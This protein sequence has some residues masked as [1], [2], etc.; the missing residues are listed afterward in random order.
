M[1]SKGGS[2][3]DMALSIGTYTTHASTFDDDI[4]DNF[5]ES[6][7]KV[8]TDEAKA[9]PPLK[10]NGN[11]DTFDVVNLRGGDDDDDSSIVSADFEDNDFDALVGEF[12]WYLRDKEKSKM[13][14]SKRLS[15]STPEQTPR[16][17]GGGSGRVLT[18]RNTTR[19]GE[20]NGVDASKQGDRKGSSSSFK[21]DD[22]RAVDNQKENVT[23]RDSLIQFEGD[24]TAR[25]ANIE[26]ASTDAAPVDEAILTQT[27][28]VLDDEKGDG[29]VSADSSDIGGEGHESLGA[30]SVSSNLGSPNENDDPKDAEVSIRVDSPSPGAVVYHDESRED[31]NTTS[32]KHMTPSRD[33]SWNEVWRKK[34]LMGRMPT[35][36]K[37]MSS[38]ID[39]LAREAETSQNKEL[40]LSELDSLKG[41]HAIT[42]PPP[43][44]ASACPPPS[45]L[46]KQAKQTHDVLGNFSDTGSAQNSTEFDP[47]VELSKILDEPPILEDVS[48]QNDPQSRIPD[49][50]SM[51][52]PDM[53]LSR[54]LDDPVG[55]DSPG[56]NTIMSR[57]RKFMKKQKLILCDES[58]AS[59]EAS[60]AS[61]SG[62]CSPLTFTDG[63]TPGPVTKTSHRQS[64]CNN[65]AV[66]EYV[67]RRRADTSSVVLSSNSF[68]A[69]TSSFVFES[70]SPN[71]VVGRQST[72]SFGN[73]EDAASSKRCADPD[74][75][76]MDY[77]SSYAASRWSISE[78]NRN[79]PLST[80]EECVVGGSDPAIVI[81]GPLNDGKENDAILAARSEESSDVKPSSESE[82]MQ[83][84][85]LIGMP[86]S[87]RPTSIIEP[88][89]S[90]DS[91]PQEEDHMGNARNS[92][93][94][95]SSAFSRKTYGSFTALSLSAIETKPGTPPSSSQTTMILKTS[96]VFDSPPSESETMN[97]ASSKATSETPPT[98]VES[99]LAIDSSHS[100]LE[101]DAD[102]LDDPWIG[103]AGLSEPNASVATMESAEDSP[104]SPEQQSIQSD[105]CS[106]ELVTPMGES[107]SSISM[108]VSVK[109]SLSSPERQTVESD[110]SD[111][112]ST[113][114][115]SFGESNSSVTTTTQVDGTTSPPEE[116]VIESDDSSTRSAF[117]DELN[118]SVA[119]PIPA[120]VDRPSSPEHQAVHSEDSSPRSTSSD[121][122][123]Y[124][125][126]ISLP[127]DDTPLPA[128]QHVQSEVSSPQW[129]M[130]SSGS[131]A[132]PVDDAPAPSEELTVQ[133]DDLSTASSSLNESNS[134]VTMTMPV[135]DTPLP[136]E[137]QAVAL[138]ASSSRST[139]SDKW[140]SSAMIALPM[141]DTGTPLHSKQQTI[142]SEDSSPRS[143]SPSKWDSSVM[144]SVPMDDNPSPPEQQTGES[145][146]TDGEL[147]DSSAQST[148][149]S[150]SGS[151][152]IMMPVLSIESPLPVEHPIAESNSP[153]PRSA[154]SGEPNS[155]A[156]VDVP[157]DEMD[158]STCKSQ[159]T[160]GS[161]MD[162]QSTQESS[163]ESS[164]RTTASLQESGSSFDGAQGAPSQTTGSATVSDALSKEDSGLT[165]PSSPPSK[166]RASKSL[167]SPKESSGPMSSFLEPARVDESSNNIASPAPKK[168]TPVKKPSSKFSNILS[169]WQ[170]KS[171]HNKNGH[172]LSP[173]SNDTPPRYSSL[174]PRSQTPDRRKS[175]GQ[176]KTLKPP[177]QSTLPKW[178]PPRTSARRKSI[179]IASISI[180]TKNVSPQKQVQESLKRPSGHEKAVRYWNGMIQSKDE[181][182][183]ELASRSLIRRES[184]GPDSLMLTVPKQ[185]PPSPSVTKEQAIVSSASTDDDIPCT[186]TQSAFSGND[187][188]MEFFL[189]KLGMAHTCGR[190]NPPILID[191]DPIGLHHILRPWQVDFLRSCDIYRGDQLVKACK[192][193]AGSLAGAMR[194][195]R[196]DRNMSCPRSV[197]CGMALHI[198]SRTCKYY[199][200]TIRRQMADGM[201]EVEPPTLGDVMTTCVD[202]EKAETSFVSVDEEEQTN[203]TKDY[204]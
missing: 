16:A 22:A 45:P 72:S 25:V 52:D 141:E 151:F 21:S 19:A 137:Q 8:R 131:I 189:P 161:E 167:K 168:T 179:D 126:M 199:V 43:K 201:V 105:G 193:R 180:P 40:V 202:K 4:K 143:T 147:D 42:W 170:E 171:E 11:K 82:S 89:L 142:Q 153:S 31:N 113:R 134:P 100:P 32:E 192:N 41:K 121:K 190:R 24:D 175:T 87:F 111:E 94:T 77:A 114:L 29:S 78:G 60:G 101:Q 124:S 183:K 85:N 12:F 23:R 15:I 132:V 166:E 27:P 91:P 74:G 3:L 62:V 108:N 92:L 57:T 14:P 136:A 69:E 125:A 104:S 138:E 10:V 48:D 135:D 103:S 191:S 20:D 164:T 149:L 139:T 96:I 9:M 51:A 1:T 5:D 150:E 127:A 195:W 70:L 176:Y 197:S 75:Y 115:A 66:P 119:T 33:D 110:E 106:R 160:Q 49:D 76:I 59:V 122:W 17:M 63:T 50:T 165:I 156:T 148:S 133:S 109:D 173:P 37:K 28:T 200:R 35:P 44:S 128:E 185:A 172:F 34:G 55:G 163:E 30:T 159:S 145:G 158:T 97:Q 112:P 203:G 7:G 155:S 130:S 178:T 80:G 98:L 194:K 46:R 13:T 186:C 65:Q 79:S 38:R 88:Q 73:N 6:D 26:V 123:D 182:N 107:N 188:L 83:E 2:H 187:E 157:F 140:D 169:Q 144:F 99:G 39:D 53:E 95:P 68:V 146:H 64:D 18:P 198:W 36:L 177:E 67:S 47:D 116:P 162:N 56:I 90:F 61:P 204:M 181:P 120:V 117:V 84:E 81:F 118:D 102:D 58:R 196:L 154:S 184:S 93:D 54:I 174:Y 71:S 86:V 152:V 129:T